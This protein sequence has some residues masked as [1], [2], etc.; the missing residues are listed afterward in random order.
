[1]NN[2]QYER[3]V[4]LKTFLRSVKH[5]FLTILYFTIVFSTLGVL[6]VSCVSQEKYKCESQLVSDRKFTDALLSSVK[7]SITLPAVIDKTISDLS[8]DGVVHKNGSPITYQ[9]LS[10]N[11]SF[12]TGSTYFYLT[13][14]LSGQ[15]KDILTI[16][17]D[18]LMENSVTQIEN[19]LKSS[20]NVKIVSKSTN[21]IKISNSKSILYVFILSGLVLGL[22]FAFAKEFHDDSVCSKEDIESLGL[23]TFVLKKRGEKNDQLIKKKD[24]KQI[25]SVTNQN[26]YNSIM[27][28]K[29]NINTTGSDKVVAIVSPQ[30]RIDRNIVALSLAKAFI[31]QNE[32]VVVVEC[33]SY[34]EHSSILQVF[35]NEG[36]SFCEIHDEM[37]KDKVLSEFMVFYAKKDL[38]TS[39]LFLSKKFKEFMNFL[40]ERFDHIIL[41]IPPLEK[42]KEIMFFKDY[43]S[44]V[45]LTA[46]QNVTERKAIFDCSVYLKNNGFPLTGVAFLK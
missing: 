16:S 5:H 7:S 44:S 42:S 11:I 19:D 3:R 27:I 31:N 10:S 6:Y 34:E 13:V 35:E 2:V 1:M 23:Q 33:D 46:L 29:N 22:G 41:A 12:N 20:I 28:L 4:T 43:I 32:S 38:N 37:I 9:D 45:V 14:Y 39:G 26:F 17:L 40:M 18:K 21:P 30:I 36:A 25:Y 15:D 24:Y 8:N